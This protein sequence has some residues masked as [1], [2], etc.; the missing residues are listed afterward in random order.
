[1][2]GGCFQNRLLLT[3]SAAGLRRRGFEP[4][5]HRRVPPNDG[6]VCLGQIGVAAAVLAGA[7]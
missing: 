6:G 7:V 5:L 3:Q 2:S 4:L 1:L